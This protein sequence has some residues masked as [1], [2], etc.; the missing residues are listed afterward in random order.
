MSTCI[1]GLSKAQDASEKETE[2]FSSCIAVRLGY[3]WIP[4]KCSPRW[5]F[6]GK[7]L[8]CYLMKEQKQP[9]KSRRFQEA[10]WLGAQIGTGFRPF[11]IC[12]LSSSRTCLAAV[13]SYF[14]LPGLS[15][16]SGLSFTIH[17]FAYPF[18][19]CHAALL[20]FPTPKLR[21]PDSLLIL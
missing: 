5:H 8:S 18:T 17:C 12:P 19:L 15:R 13:T 10:T 7:P 4:L 1:R 11:T 14:M 20:V 16:H 3:Q 2:I 6:L 9:W 21:S